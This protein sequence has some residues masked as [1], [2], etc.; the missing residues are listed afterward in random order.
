[1]AYSVVRYFNLGNQGASVAQQNIVN[2]LIGSWEGEG[3]LFG[4]N[5]EFQMN[6]EWTLGKKFVR[7]T[8]QNKVIEAQCC[9]W[10]TRENTR[11]TKANN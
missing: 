6:W 10:K 3:K 5:S 2:N 8:F 1:M 4:S 9:T 7:L 11:K